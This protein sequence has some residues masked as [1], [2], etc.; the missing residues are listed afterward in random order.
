MIYTIPS[1]RTLL[2]GETVKWYKHTKLCTGI[3]RDD[4]DSYIVVLCIN[5]GGEKCCKKKKI[6]K[7][8]LITKEQEKMD[9]RRVLLQNRFKK[10]TKIQLLEQVKNGGLSELEQEVITE[11][12]ITKGTTNAELEAYDLEVPESKEAPEQSDEDEEDINESIKVEATDKEQ[13]DG[14]VDEDS[15]A[16]IPNEGETVKDGKIVQP[17]VVENEEDVKYEDPLTEEEVELQKKQ[18]EQRNKKKEEKKPVKIDVNK[19]TRKDV[20]YIDPNL[21]TVDEGFNTRFD[22]GDI[23]ELKNSIIENGVRIP[24]RGYKEGEKYVVIDGHR[25]TIATLKA[26]AEGNDIARVPFISEKK[27]TMEER[28]FDILLSNDGKPLTSIEL[29]ETYRRLKDYGYTYTEIANKIGKT[30]KSVSDLVLVAESSK[31]LKEL[32]K[33]GDISATLVFEIKKSMGNDELA[34]KIIKD[35]VAEKKETFKDEQKKQKVTKKDIKNIIQKQKDNT[36]NKEKHKEVDEIPE[37]QDKKVDKVYNEKQVK[38]LLQ[39]QKDACISAL[40]EEMRKLLNDVN[41]VL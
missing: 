15:G 11:V 1:K 12:L 41:L 6:K 36:V 39:K 5:I 34:E 9:V 35:K 22:L 38:E 16:I 30:V 3:V 18:E 29:G 27:R 32:I 26:I 7:D 33:G 31:E 23:D 28:I 13:E 14:I 4:L 17:S 40:P 21:L 20:L 8:I 10:M 25:R 24:I 19:T 2:I 37:N